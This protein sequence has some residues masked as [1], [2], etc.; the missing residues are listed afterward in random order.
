MEPTKLDGIRKVLGT[1][2]VYSD[3]QRCREILELYPPYIHHCSGL[4]CMAYLHKNRNRTRA[5]KEPREHLD[6]WSDCH[7]YRPIAAFPM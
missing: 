7:Q 2:L 4:S 5:Q 3:N 1:W 6:R